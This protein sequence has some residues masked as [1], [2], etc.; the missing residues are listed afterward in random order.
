[1]IVPMPWDEGV[2][3]VDIDLT[4]LLYHNTLKTSQDVPQRSPRVH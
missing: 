3:S 4:L 1:M 2:Y